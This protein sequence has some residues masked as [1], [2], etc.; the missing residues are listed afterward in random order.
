MMMGKSVFPVYVPGTLKETRGAC[1]SRILPVQKCRSH[2]RVK[3]A[4]NH[5]FHQNVSEIA[6]ITEVS[7]LFPLPKTREQ[8]KVNGII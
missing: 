2:G 8:S 5:G 7:Y 3:H 6:Y 1:S 4:G